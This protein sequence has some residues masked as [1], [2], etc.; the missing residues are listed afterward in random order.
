[1]L[2]QM[3]VVCWYTTG[4]AGMLFECLA[5]HCSSGWKLECVEL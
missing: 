4:A 2:L 5:V 3:M 1:M